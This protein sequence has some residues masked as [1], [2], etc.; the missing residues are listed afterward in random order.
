MT[1]KANKRVSIALTNEQ[2]DLASKV[3]AEKGLSRS[4][5]FVFA[6]EEYIKEQNQAAMITNYIDWQIDQRLRGL[7]QQQEKTVKEEVQ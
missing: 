6:L 2:F 4:A 3:A 5:M 7:S 1:R